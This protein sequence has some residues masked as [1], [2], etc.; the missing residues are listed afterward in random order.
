[1]PL[2][3]PVND[4]QIRPQYM[5][6]RRIIDAIFADPYNEELILEE[7]GEMSLEKEKQTLLNARIMRHNA[8]CRELHAR[9]GSL[10]DEQRQLT[11]SDG[12]FQHTTIDGIYDA[13]GGPNPVRDQPD[14]LHEAQPLQ[15]QPRRPDQPIQRVDP[16]LA[17][18]PAL[19]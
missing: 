3:R 2:P 4:A 15:P 17:R 9:A 1:M 19:P 18:W 7:A 14:A 11:L 5:R 13:L 16:L 10:R 8:E 6:P 12:S